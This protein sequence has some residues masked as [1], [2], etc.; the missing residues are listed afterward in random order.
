MLCGF[1]FHVLE[2]CLVLHYHCIKTIR[3]FLPILL[4]FSQKEGKIREYVRV[5]C[6]TDFSKV[7]YSIYLVGDVFLWKFHWICE[8]K[9]GAFICAGA[10]WHQFMLPVHIWSSVTLEEKGTF[11]F[12]LVKKNFPN[13]NQ[14]LMTILEE[15]SLKLDTVISHTIKL[16]EDQ[17]RYAESRTCDKLSV[18]SCSSRLK[19]GSTLGFWEPYKN[20]KPVILM[21]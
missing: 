16:W 17:R 19:T 2:N 15:Q 5:I 6:N 10:F 9:F 4:I 7:W 1:F 18:Q 8:K 21:P 12:T 3:F 20:K 13:Q 11:R 14:N